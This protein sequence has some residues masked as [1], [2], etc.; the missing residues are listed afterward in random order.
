MTS[1]A[2]PLRRALLL[3]LLLLALT[4]CERTLFERAPAEAAAGCDPALV[5]RWLSLGDKP[6]DE[7]EL[8]ATVDAQCRLVTVE[9]KAGGDRTSAATTLRSGKADGVRYLWLDADWANA[10]FEV[11]R[12]AL[13]SAGDVYVFAWRLRG[14]R[15]ELAAPPHRALAHKVLDKDIEGGVL[16]HD[17]S[18]TVRLTGERDELRKL[19][20][21]YRVFRFDRPLRFRRDAAAP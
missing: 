1:A 6:E 18:L 8:V 2:A 14:E 16:M 5:G 17:D 21:T 10:S 3:P 7:G 13:D 15:L 9:R 19:L 11:K 12:T 4:G 20:R